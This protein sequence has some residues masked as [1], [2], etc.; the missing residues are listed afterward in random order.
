MQPDSYNA[1]PQENGNIE[2][3][4]EEDDVNLLD[5]PELP[6]SP[7]LARS[8][9]YLQH[10]V[11][12]PPI[13]LIGMPLPANFVVADTLYP[14]AP[15]TPEKNGYCQSKYLWDAN[16]E[17]LHGNVKNTKYW[18]DHRD[19]PIFSERPDNDS[20]VAIDD[21]L[22]KLKE[23]YAN[24][25]ASEERTRNSRSQSRSISVRQDSGDFRGDLEALERNLAEL[26]AR[27]AEM[28]RNRQLAKGKHGS[29]SQSATPTKL[30]DGQ[31][32]VKQE[33]ES[34]PQSPISEKPLKSEYNT[35]D[36]LASLGVTGPPKPVTGNGGHYHTST[37]C[38]P[39]ENYTPRSRSS[40][41]AEP[42][43]VPHDYHNNES[44]QYAQGYGY[45]QPPPPHR[46]QSWPEGLD[47]S[48]LSAGPHYINTYSY[49]I[50]AVDNGN[51][52]INYGADGQVPF[53]IDFRLERIGSRKRSYSR[54][55]STSDEEETPA[56]R[57]ED[58]ITPKHKRRQ[59]KIEAAYG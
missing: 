55:D 18:K 30:D 35:E 22:S 23:R 10:T 45:P 42:S 5:I 50:N 41:K 52:Q 17:I 40:S 48:P 6:S 19:D 27:A 59:P 7:S 3:E 28:E 38:L 29:P 36:V 37:H 16:L 8:G 21:V 9:I 53:L 1:G 2:D 44:P 49:N 54:R 33:D 56:R 12:S 31:V 51:S 11:I 25:E 46:Q 15:P 34:P 57:Q 43:Q 47:G 32:N 20:I 39:N 24:G 26:K 4:D 58:D 14:I 13:N